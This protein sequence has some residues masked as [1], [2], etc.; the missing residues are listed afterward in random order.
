MIFNPNKSDCAYK[1]KE[2]L[3]KLIDKKV[4]FELK[5]KKRQRT[6]QQNRYLHLIFKQVAIETGYSIN[7]VKQVIFKKVV[8]SDIFVRYSEFN[9]VE[10]LISTSELDTLEMTRAIER[11]R[12]YCSLEFGI[13]IPAPNEEEKINAWE[14][15]LSNQT[16]Y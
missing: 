6:N 13:Y 8:N 2:Y 16:F 9:G 5:E 12:D 1:A 7:E 10:Y 11:F 14:A 4:F 3:D 15:E